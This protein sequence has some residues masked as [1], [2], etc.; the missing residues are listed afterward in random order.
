MHAYR[1]FCEKFLLSVSVCVVGLLSVANA[2]ETPA[3][4]FTSIY[5]FC[6][7]AHCPD[8][9][10][11]NGSLVQGPD[12]SFYGTTTTGSL[13]GDGTVFKISSGGA[14]VTLHAFSGNDGN[15]PSALILATDGNLYGTT[16]MGGASC[17][18]GTGLCGT[19]FRITPSGTLT[20]LY[21]FCSRTNCTDG[22]FPGAAL[23][24]GNDGNLY[25]TTEHGGIA[26]QCSPYGCGTIFR[27]TLNGMFN[28][29]YSFCPQA[30]CQFLAPDG[31]YPLAPL[32]QG[33]DG[34]LYGTTSAGGSDTCTFGCG[35]FFKYSGTGG[36]TQLHQFV[37]SVDGSG[38]GQMVQATD[39]NFYGVTS[40]TL[41]RGTP[42]GLVATI[43][44]FMF[45]DGEMP[46]GVLQATD[47]NLY[48]V[49]QQGGGSNNCLSGCGTI[50]ESNLDGGLRT[51]HSFSGSDGASPAGGLLLAT[52]GN[53]YGATSLGGSSGNCQG[54][55]GT[56]FKLST[57]LAAF[58]AT[59]P[60]AGVAGTPVAILGTNLTGATSVKFNGT[61]ATFTE[62]SSSELMANVPAGATT[63]TVQV[64]LPGGTLTSNADFQVGGAIQFVPVTPCRVIN[65]I[66]SGA[67]QGGTYQ[68]FTI[69]QAAGCGIPA[70]AA[71]Y[72]MNITV[73]PEHT[74]G[75]LTIW[76]EGEIQPYVSTLNSPDGR[77]KANAVIVPAGNNAVSIYVTDTTNVLGDISGYFQSANGQTLEFYPRT[78]CRVVDTRVGSTEPPGLGP[79]SLSAME[80]RTLPILSSPCL[81]NLPQQ[82]LA[83]SFNVTA[84]PYPAGQAL[85]FL[86]VW[87][88]NEPQPGVSTLNNPTATVVANAAIVPANPTNGDID[89]FAYNG[90]D[91]LIDFNGYFAPAG[92]GGYQLYTAAPCRAY[93]SRNYGPPFMGE[94]T[95]NIV[96][97]QCA[98]PGTAKAYVFNATVIPSGVMPYLTLWADG[99]LQP[100]VS[101]LNAY[102][103]FVTSNMAI[104]GNNEGLT[105]TFAAGLTQL[106]LDITGYFAP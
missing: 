30:N 22:F 24:E 64:A 70:S 75:Y 102:D 94:R 21:T 41:F 92:Q 62:V 48:G 11:P 7:Q 81:G 57:G 51:L 68:N 99:S 29:L 91:L 3:T 19:I 55:C 66:P 28:T 33:A 87:P 50:F 34:S 20:T 1:L 4:S 52:D 5:S 45:T 100:M 69:A 90:T 80:T 2:S 46:T 72:A 93:D 74:L 31:E 54:G 96:K 77:V 95:V 17:S 60:S 79:P 27:I 16:V 36:L 67:I 86:T 23:L 58:V 84:V 6:R 59:V 38:P 76:P 56:V 71:A 13:S 105:D 43:H 97:S 106:I 8:G 37:N 98:P 65:T 32:V 9:N 89:V 83:Y 47:G 44:L 103:G 63:G 15:Q 85:N 35:T 42:G 18:R 82:P 104:V 101:T 53:F 78:P 88:S 73:L 40:G 61:S 49:T 14:L 12:G 10:S 26:G 25:G 39:G